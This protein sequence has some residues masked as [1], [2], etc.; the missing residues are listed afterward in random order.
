MN[1]SKILVTYANTYSIVD[2]KTGAVNEGC[3]LRYFFFGETG[4][5]FRST[6]NMSGG[7]VGY[8][9]AKCSLDIEKRKKISF[10]PGVYDATFEM[11]IG[12]DGKPV[13]KVVDLDYVAEAEILVKKKQ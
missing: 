2:E 9:L 7:A 13:M 10:V 1:K 5:G 8:Q 11:S 4:E 6:N 12:S 3:S